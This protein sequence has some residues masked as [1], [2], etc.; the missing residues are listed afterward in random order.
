M[1]FIKKHPIIVNLLLAV[2]AVILLIWITLSWLD[3]YTRHGEVVTVPKEV[4]GLSVSEAAGLLSQNELNYEVS[5][6]IYAK[7][8]KPGTVQKIFPTEGNTVKKGRTI[9]L[10]VYSTHPPLLVVPNV[11]DMSQRNA[12]SL[13][14]TIGFENINTKMVNGLY[15]DLVVGLEVKGKEVLPGS[16]YHLDT[17]ITI[18]VSSGNQRE[19]YTIPTDSVIIRDTTPE[20]SWF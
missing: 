20:E 4:I 1:N 14:K 5:D 6:S 13:L 3:N 10:T 11:E 17:P 12:T 8:A 15:K 2:V 9:Q 19:E 18:L 7:N 16:R